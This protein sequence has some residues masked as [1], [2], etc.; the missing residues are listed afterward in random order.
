MEETGYSGMEL[1]GPQQRWKTLIHAEDRYKLLEAENKVL[2]GLSTQVE[3][4]LKHPE[5]G[6][7]WFAARLRP[8]K[9]QEGNVTQI[10]AHFVD[11]N[12]FKQKEEQLRK[13]AYY[14]ELTSL[15]NRKMLHVHL[16]K[17]LA[18]SQRH[19]HTFAVMFIDI[20]DFKQVNDTLGHEA[21]DQLLKLIARRMEASIRQEDIVARL[22]GDEFV[23]VFEEVSQE[24]VK[25]IAQRL[26][27]SVSAPYQ[28]KEQKTK[29]SLTIGVSFYPNH[30]E[31]L[32]TLLDRADQA[33]Y[34]AKKKG[35]NRF[36]LYDDKLM[37]ELKESGKLLEQFLHYFRREYRKP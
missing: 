17:V 23:A 11:I 28:I 12:G 19:Q 7:K 26:I 16:Q 35:K 9:D 24:E 21:G 36:E 22:A 8:L 20:D 6:F 30:G 18:K 1:F 33:M 37:Q 10:A 34:I 15:P 4:R 31:D 32:F 2:R 27:R 5:Q 3:I 25:N 14:D 29:I 13:M